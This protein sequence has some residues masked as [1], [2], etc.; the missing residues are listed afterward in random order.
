MFKI[1]TLILKQQSQAVEHAT[2]TRTVTASSQGHAFFKV[3]TAELVRDFNGSEKEFNDC[4][5]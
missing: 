5:R 3:K 4:D 2:A 1:K